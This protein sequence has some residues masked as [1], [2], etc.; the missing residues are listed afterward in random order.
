MKKKLLLI[1]TIALMTV[2][3]TGCQFI[4]DFF[5]N[6]I[7]YDNSNREFSQK[8]AS[9]IEPISDISTPPA[10][11]LE[12]KPA[13]ST[14]SDYIA[15]SAY[16]YS[17]TPSLGEAKLLIIPVWFNN[18]N[19]F[20]KDDHKEQVREDI[21]N[22][23]FGNNE[24]VGWRSV[25]S[26]Y[27]EES[28]GALTIDGTVSAWYE[29]NKNYDYYAV[30]DP[31]EE[32]G[33][34]KTSALV[35][36]ATK[37]YFDNH[38]SENRTDYDCDKDGYLDGVMLIY[39]AP[40]FIALNNDEKENLWAYCYW[41]QDYTVQNPLNPGLNAFFWA[42]YDFMYGN[43]VA[44]S[45]TG[46]RYSHGDTTR[47]KLDG[48]TYIHEMGHMFGLEDYYDYS[49]HSYSPA[50]GF[51]MQDNN[52]GIHD[53]FSS[54]AL[55]W[56]KAIIP[57]NDATIDLK[58]FTTSGEII[59][60]SPSWNAY[61]SPFDEYIILE[62]F[63]SDGLNEL[64]TSYGYMSTEGY[65]YPMGT[66]ES[67]IRVWHVDARLLYTRTGEISASQT[68][69]NP[70]MPGVAVISMNTNTYDDGDD[71][72]RQYLS[73]LASDP[74]EDYYDA[75]YANYN[76]LQLIR[77][78]I[79]TTSKPTDDLSGKSLFKTG[80]SFSMEKYAKQFVNSTKLNNGVELGYTFTVNACNNGYASISIKKS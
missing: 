53:P 4:N 39:A 19:K 43:N 33:A 5:S 37:W 45:R 10:D 7:N 27:E 26:Y 50:G 46:Y 76:L 62:Y 47:A 22:I 68:T 31:T 21:A 13:S 80:D 61:N 73:I 49:S 55:G 75:K 35:E 3:L 1:S 48:H 42:S 20:I 32:S 12:A 58:P 54:F 65:D 77:N 9:S 17:C 16:A 15:N 41:L 34:P 71:Y 25:K 69:T 70:K 60:L 57:N 67:G 66:K 24:D 51:S 23:Y 64:D 40:D 59:I 6:Y 78:N 52:V 63:T 11:D 38:V 18:S 30:D 14:Y 8:V 29:P 56:A 36:S 72:T 79:R 2:T 28:H 44:M 74:T